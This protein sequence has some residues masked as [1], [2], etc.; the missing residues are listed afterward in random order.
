MSKN[1]QTYFIY[2][3]WCRKNAEY[4]VEVRD[5]EGEMA[6]QNFIRPTKRPWRTYGGIESEA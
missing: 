2:S 6:F 3:A 1:L 5:T 4:N